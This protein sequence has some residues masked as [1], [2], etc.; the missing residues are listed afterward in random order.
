MQRHDDRDIEVKSA[1]IT[2]EA[3]LLKEAGLSIA[4]I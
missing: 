1:T 2:K 4:A 3:R